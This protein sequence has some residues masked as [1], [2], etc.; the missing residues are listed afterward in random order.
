MAQLLDVQKTS[1][2]CE[3]QFPQAREIVKRLTDAKIAGVVDDQ[4]RPQRACFFEVLL[5]E[6]TFVVEPQAGNHLMRDEPGAE[7][8]LGVVRNAAVKDQLHVFG[9][10]EINVVAQ[11]L[12][13]EQPARERTIK[14]LRAGEL[15]LLNKQL[16]AEAGR[17]VFGRKRM[18]QPLGPLLPEGLDLG[19]R[20]AIAD[21]LKPLGSGATAN[22]VVKRFE[23]DALLGQLTLDVFVAV[24]AELG[25]AREVGTESKPKSP[26]SDLTFAASSCCLTGIL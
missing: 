10:S 5:E 1:V 12:L 18:R 11:H 23:G 4:F 17:T 25:V 19:G 15:G 20:Q 3:G 26:G 13:E 8:G 22:A 21:L 6:R 24:E 16:I 9:A 7:A 2:G 14:D